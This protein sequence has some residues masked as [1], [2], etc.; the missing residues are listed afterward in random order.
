MGGLKNSCVIVGAGMAGLTAAR[1]LTAAGWNVVVLEKASGVG[2]RIA[3]RRI[4]G[5]RA[6]HGAQF[7]TVRDPVFAEAAAQWQTSGWVKPWFTEAGHTRYCGVEGMNALMKH[8]AEPF[9]VR[10]SNIVERVE[11]VEGGWRIIAA[12]APL[13]QA[14]AL[15]LTPP[16]PQSAALL[17]GCAG[18]LPDVFTSALRSIHYDPCFAMLI[19]LA[20]PSD[21]PDPG[22]VRPENSPIAW[23]ADNRR[24]GIADTATVLTLHTTP[25][26]A[27]GHFDLA[28]DEM[29]RF[30]LDCVV[31]WLGSDVVEWQIHRWRYSRPV[32]T[33]PGPCLHTKIP[34]PLAIAGD[35]FAG[36]RI[37]GAFLSG[38]AA[39]Q[40]LLRG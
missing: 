23:I 21:I 36:P 7:F 6:D 15:L 26:F 5:A 9:D 20:G 30:L 19:K 29:A 10:I 28:H 38:L 2:G 31:E 14:G 18:Q 35:A 3:T 39:A 24:K 27:R 34:A 12:G 1:T 22:Y 11:P 16:A 37:E 40:Q 4:D 32:A 13:L 8:L 33:Y 25:E 17:A